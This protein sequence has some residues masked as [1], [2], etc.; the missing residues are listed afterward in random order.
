MWPVKNTF[1]HFGVASALPGR[2]PRSNS[3][4]PAPSAA[5]LTST[6]AGVDGSLAEYDADEFQ[7]PTV[8]LH[9]TPIG[10]GGGSL[11]K[12]DPDHLQSP[13][14]ELHGSFDGS[15]G[16]EFGS[17]EKS[18]KGL[19]RSFAE[20]GSNR[21]KSHIDPSQRSVASLDTASLGLDESL[22]TSSIDSSEFQALPRSVEEHQIVAHEMAT[23]KPCMYFAFKKDSCRKGESCE[24][25]HSCTHEQAKAFK[26]QLKKDARRERH[27][28]ERSNARGVSKKGS[29]YR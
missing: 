6:I 13:T 14:A 29:S 28:R 2:P 21:I 22:G 27:W 8:D 23:C 3:A 16:S 18:T 20:N 17:D 11:I 26:R 25:C 12:S 4:P 24:F 9:S 10:S 5:A 7:Y 19:S 15:G 1:I